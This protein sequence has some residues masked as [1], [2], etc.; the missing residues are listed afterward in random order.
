M[1]NNENVVE[2]YTNKNP[3]PAPKIPFFFIRGVL[4]MP[5]TLGYCYYNLGCLLEVVVDITGF[6]HRGG[7]PAIDLK[8]IGTDLKGSSMSTS[9]MVPE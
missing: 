6:G 9:F 8:L 2:P 5:K 3:V 4:E 1:T 7:G